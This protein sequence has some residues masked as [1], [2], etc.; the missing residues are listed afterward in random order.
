[1]GE[2]FYYYDYSTGKHLDYKPNPDNG[3]HIIGNPYVYT[4]LPVRDKLFVGTADGMLVCR[5]DR[6]GV[7]KQEST[8]LLERIAVRHFAAAADGSV[9]WAA[10]S[11]GLVKIDCQSLETHTYTTADG[12]PINSIASVCVDGNE[13]WIGTDC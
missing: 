10:T 8:K 3:V 4:I 11:E 6:E 1:M 2:G 12:L 13:L 7:I 9:V 5:P